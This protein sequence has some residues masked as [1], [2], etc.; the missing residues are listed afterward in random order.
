MIHGV[1]GLLY[2][3]TGKSR[4]LLMKVI[5]LYNAMVITRLLWMMKCDPMVGNWPVCSVVDYAFAVTRKTRQ[6]R[7]DVWLFRIVVVEAAGC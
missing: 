5:H 6:R 4:F 1:Y 7:I 2:A 3:I